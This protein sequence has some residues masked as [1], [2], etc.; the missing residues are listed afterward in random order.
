MLSLFFFF[1]N[2]KQKKFNACIAYKGTDQLYTV[3]RALEKKLVK[4]NYFL[5]FFPIKLYLLGLPARAHTE[6]GRAT[7]PHASKS[8]YDDTMIK[9]KPSEAKSEVTSKKARAKGLY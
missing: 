8:N 7:R 6:R 2:T 5:L 9:S 4:E 1:C 3:Y